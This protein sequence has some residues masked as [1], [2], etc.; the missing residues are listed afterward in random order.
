MKGKQHHEENESD[1]LSLPCR[2]DLFSSPCSRSNA[3][4]RIGF[5][6]SIFVKRATADAF[7]YTFLA[8]RTDAAQ[9]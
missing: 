3:V 1:S 6:G 2:D 5:G 8:G 7:C 4:A 9:K